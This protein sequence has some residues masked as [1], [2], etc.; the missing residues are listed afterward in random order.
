MFNKLKIGAVVP[1]YNEQQSI[2]QVVEDLVNLIHEGKPVFDD[3]VVCDN[4]STDSTAAYASKGGARV[5]RE[6]QRGY[7]SACLAAL[8]H[9]SPVDVIVFVD[10]DC[11]IVISDILQLILKI[12]EGYDFVLGSREFNQAEKGALFLHQKIGNKFFVLLIRLLWGVSYRDLCPLRAV[13]STALKALNMQDQTYGWTLEMQIKAIL[14]RLKF[15]EVPISYR[16]RLG[17]SKI[18]GNVKAS[19]LVMSKMISLIFSMYLKTLFN[20]KVKSS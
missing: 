16:K 6:A 12:N 18:S 2:Y 14:H 1:A 11:S 15:C 9:L 5:V 17:K 8:A 7:G 3:I 10:G 4:G 20:R 19:L 13:R